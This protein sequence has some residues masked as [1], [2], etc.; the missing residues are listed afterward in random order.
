MPHSADQTLTR[1]REWFANTGGL[2][3]IN[4]PDQAMQILIGGNHCMIDGLKILNEIEDAHTCATSGKRAGP[5]ICPRKLM[6]P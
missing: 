4:D 6:M 2:V 1:K 3:E 5:Q